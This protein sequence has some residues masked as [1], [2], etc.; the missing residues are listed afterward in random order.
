MNDT[1]T[2]TPRTDAN[3]RFVYGHI[4]R[5]WC[6]TAFARQLE[7]E[8]NESRAREKQLHEAL[9]ASKWETCN[10]R[11]GPDGDDAKWS[12]YYAMRD[13]ALTLPAPPVVLKAEY[14]KVVDCLD[15]ICSHLR[16]KDKTLPSWGEVADRLAEYHAKLTAAEAELEELRG[17]SVHTCGDSCQRPMCML[18]SR[19]NTA[20]ADADALASTIRAIRLRHDI[21][22]T[23]DSLDAHDARRKP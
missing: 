6:D 19:L 5:Q 16:N 10:S 9:E 1:P 3:A 22:Q 12:K 18:R 4:D 21:W 8:L 15:D 17:L 7:R 23:F 13:E 20:E 14:D 11:I 2:P